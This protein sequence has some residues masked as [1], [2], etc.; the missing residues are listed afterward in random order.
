MV[1][2]ATFGACLA[3]AFEILGWDS[4][5]GWKSLWAD[6]PKEAVVP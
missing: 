5:V 4:Q 1:G 6:A 2:T 3:S